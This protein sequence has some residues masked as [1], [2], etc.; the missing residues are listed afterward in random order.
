V[1]QPSHLVAD[2]LDERL[3]DG[4]GRPAGR[5]D[6]VIIVVRDGRPPLVTAIEVSPITL[7]A[8]VSRRFARWYAAI[9]ARLG[10]GRGVPFRI[11]WT[12]LEFIERA[13]RFRGDVR[14]TPINA[15]ER[16]LRAAFVSRLPWS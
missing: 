8:R 9:D 6:G 14:S 12:D 15:L 4:D 5:V 10:R 11:A 3:V 2:V 7:A 1:T 16:K 13:I